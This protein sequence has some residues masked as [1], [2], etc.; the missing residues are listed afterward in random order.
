[1]AASMDRSAHLQQP[2][3][4]HALAYDF[5]LQD[6]WDFGI[7]SPA[8]D[9]G[10]SSREGA[11]LSTFIAV[12]DEVMREAMNSLGPT[13]LL[14]RLRGLLGRAFHWDDEARNKAV[15][16]HESLRHR[17][18]EAERLEQPWTQGDDVEIRPVDFGGFQLVYRRGDE[19]L[20]E[21]S[22]ATVHALMHL[23]W[24]PHDG[25]FAPRMAV[26]A[27]KKGLLGHVYMALIKPFRYAIV[28][29]AMQRAV[30]RAWQARS[31]A[32]P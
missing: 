23:G 22:N 19:A 17:L 29:P 14:F 16:A 7:V 27:K 32:K 25:G 10:G 13:G 5:E 3:R 2:W 20:Y 28:Y 8:G 6:V 4:V 9:P 11:G 18:A 12:L 24:T 1:M 26:Y 31:S 15:P 30:R 21:L